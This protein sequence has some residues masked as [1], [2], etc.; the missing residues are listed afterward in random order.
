M[1][2]Q[3]HRQREDLEETSSS[4]SRDETHQPHQNPQATLPFE[5]SNQYFYKHP[6][7]VVFSFN[8]QLVINKWRWWVKLGL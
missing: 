7:T 4:G 5:L 1:S 2:E 6:D 3:N 8:T